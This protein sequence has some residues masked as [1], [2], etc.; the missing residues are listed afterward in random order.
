M[1]KADDID[2]RIGMP[3]VEAEWAKFEREV[4]KRAG[5]RRGSVSRVAA[6]VA[7][8]L[9]LSLTALASVYYVRVVRPA[10]QATAVP[11]VERVE[12]L[13]A[14]TQPTD[15][16]AEFVFDNV[17]ML[18]IARTLGEHYGVEPVFRSEQAKEVRLYARIGKEKSL[19]E[20]VELLSH[21]KKVK[22]SVSGGKLIIE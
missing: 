7:L 1:K 15:S 8:M 18:T 10:R 2:R 12:S 4:I 11:A 13:A 6:A 5:P 14:N 9:G 16:V 21:F 22:L 17:D 3:D 20:V 19:D